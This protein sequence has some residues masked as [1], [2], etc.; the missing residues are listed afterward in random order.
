MI[1]HP[2]FL[3]YSAVRFIWRNDKNHEELHKGKGGLSWPWGMQRVAGASGVIHC[4]T[5]PGMAAAARQ[6]APVGGWEW[7][8]WPG[9]PTQ[10]GRCVSPACSEPAEVGMGPCPA[11]PSGMLRVCVVYL[12]SRSP[13]CGPPASHPLPLGDPLSLGNPVSLI[14]GAQFSR[15]L[16]WDRGL[17]LPLKA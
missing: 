15:H 14:Q 1:C 9:T 7:A 10:V 2:L 13:T 6:G 8:L 16:S 3:F 17:C 5:S 12:G 11:V 4:T